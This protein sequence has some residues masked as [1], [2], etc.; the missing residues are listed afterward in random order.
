[1][2]KKF[3]MALLASALFVSSLTTTAF[4]AQ[5][6]KNVDVYYVPL[7]F[8]FDGEQV[9]PPQDQQAF[10]Y[11]GST[12]VPLRFISYSLNKAVQWEGDTYTVSVQDP[13]E[14]DKLEIADHNLNTKVRG[15]KL[16]DEFNASQLT[17]SNIEVYQEKVKYIFDGKEKEI[18]EDLPGLFVNNKLYV[19]LRF[20]SESVGNKI[21]WNDKSYTITAVSP[22]K[23]K[24]DKEAAEKAA[25][26]KAAA[27]KK[28]AE[29]KKK[30]TPATIGGAGGGGSVGGGGSSTT[31]S[32]TDIVN[33]YLDKIRGLESEANAYFTEALIKFLGNP[34]QQDE[35]KAAAKTKLA[36]YDSR[37]YGWM[38]SLS[39][40]LT[41]NNYQTAKV[42]ELS[43]KYEEKKEEQKKLLGR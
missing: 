8:V 15:G 5:T 33:P 11:E 41:A 27:E 1:M 3:K 23:L 21:E 20:F 28:A 32:E 43:S 34:A 30:D 10:I 7:Q 4:G 14:K 39:Q 26:E 12:Y 25:A 9:A 18:G 38:D 40:E 17:S 6:P 35:I 37:F 36:E 13:K 24:A 19:P 16:R 42:T 2:M 29:E 31:K 22:A